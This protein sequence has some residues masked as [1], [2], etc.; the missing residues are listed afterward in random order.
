MGDLSRN[1]MA[2]EKVF[3]EGHAVAAVA[4]TSE[5]IARK[6]LKLIDVD[7]EILPHVIDPVEAM[8]PDAPILHDYLRTK[9]VP[10]ARE[11]AHQRG[12]A[13]GIRDAA[14][15]RRASARPM[16]SS[17][18]SSG[19]GRSIR[20]TSSRRAASPTATEDGQVEVWCCTQGHFVVRAQ[21]A[22]TAEDGRLEDP[23]HR[24]RARRRLRRQDHLLRRGG[25][26]H[27]VAQ[28][29]PPGEDR[30]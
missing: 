13:P 17:S 4:A 1:L 10:G 19:P 27:A 6:A 2:R 20:A 15:S 7:Y 12:R 8:Q 28:G 3:Y 9:G 16:S 11:Q 21:L 24:I 26:G 25:G 14:T 18:A 30:A 22:G 23:R 29:Q 5:A